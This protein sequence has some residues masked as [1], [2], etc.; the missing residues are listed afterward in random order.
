M[1]Q[2]ARWMLPWEQ[3]QCHGAGDKQLQVKSRKNTHTH[4]QK[5]LFKDIYVAE[6]KEPFLK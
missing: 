2:L 1:N 3:G 6:E 4:T 5:S